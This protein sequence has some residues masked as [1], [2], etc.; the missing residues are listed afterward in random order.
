[1]TTG[2]RIGLAASRAAIACLG[3]VG[4]VANLSA[5]GPRVTVETLDDSL[6]GELA[7]LDSINGLHLQGDNHIRLPVAEVL[8]VRFKS[9]PTLQFEASDRGGELTLVDG[10][11]LAYRSYRLIDGVLLLRTP[12][13]AEAEVRLT[14][15]RSWW[16][17][18]ERPVEDAAVEAG[19]VADVLWVKP[20]QGDGVSSVQGVVLS[21]EAEGVRFAF[22]G[23]DPTDTVLVPWA[24][25]AGIGFFREE[26]RTPT[27][28]CVVS[29][30]GGGRLAA[31]VIRL[32]ADRFVWES[33]HGRGV[34][35]LDSI[36][37]IDLSA[38][39]VTAVSAMAPV[40]ASWRPYFEVGAIGTGHAFDASLAGEP[41]RLRE[42]DPRS[43]RD[44]PAVAVL[45]EHASGVAMKSRGELRF[46]LP[47]GA[48]R[49]KGR[50]GLDPSCVRSGSAEAA[51][52]ADGRVVWSSVVDGETRPLELNAPLD[53]AATLTLRVDYGDNLDAGDHVHFASLRVIQ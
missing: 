5:Q 53:G 6:S 13:G 12:Y 48:I 47:P 38:G 31:D 52:L 35:S 4:A 32:E 45:R 18:A 15:V 20:R 51:V 1:M 44:W 7:S 36:E 9:E 2:E 26:T 46:A 14:S 21:V 22:D 29:L 40:D 33:E 10:S 17:T 27:P 43:P 8:G 39:R 28:A 24:R 16:L 11:R 49:L 3:V 25:L 19:R 37:A 50:V 23:E 42:P 34:L 30:R 41:L